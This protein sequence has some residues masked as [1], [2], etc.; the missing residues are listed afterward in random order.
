M[1]HAFLT[2]SRVILCYI[3]KVIANSV[4]GTY[5]RRAE[6]PTQ[7][8]G[9][10][11]SAQVILET[12]Q[13]ASLALRFTDSTSQQQLQLEFV[14]IGSDQQRWQIEGLRCPTDSFHAL[15][16]ARD[17]LDSQ[18]WELTRT[19]ALQLSGIYEFVRSWEPSRR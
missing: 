12:T 13:R 18:H 7:L 6:Q 16:F 9:Q 19:R 8:V 14:F 3:R 4:G 11:V 17:L 1:Q 5:K 15:E 10:F 2:C